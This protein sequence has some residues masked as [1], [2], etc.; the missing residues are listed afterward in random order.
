MRLLTSEPNGIVDG[1]WEKSDDHS[2]LVLLRN[3]EWW[4]DHPTAALNDVLDVDGTNVVNAATAPRSKRALAAFVYDLGSDEVTDVSAPT[5]NF[6][7]FPFITGM[8][9]SLPATTPPNDTISVTQTPRLGTG[10]V[11]INVPNWASNDHRSTL[12]F[13]DYH[14]TRPMVADSPVAPSADAGPLLAYLTW[15][16][17]DDDGGAPITGYRIID[18]SDATVATVA[19]DVFDVAILGLAEGSTP[20]FR[21]IA[22]NSEGESAPSEA[23]A[24][25]TIEGAV[26]DFSDLAEDDPFFAE[27][28]WAVDQGLAAG[29]DDG[30]FGAARPVTRQAAAA[31]LHRLSGSPVG[32]F[33]DPG[34]TDVPV[35]HPFYDEIAWLADEG[36]TEGQPDGSFGPTQPLSRQALAAFL[37]RLAD[38][39]AGPFPDPGFTDV[40]VGHPFYDEIAWLAAAGITDGYDDGTFR[41]LTTV[42]RQ[43]MM[44]FLYRHTL[45]FT[46]IL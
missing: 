1:L 19:A 23:S 36:I 21:V 32:P 41:P 45:V 20:T 26:A 14:V 42:S 37:H 3:K 33:P 18:E 10:P 7:A 43:A 4:G 15:T 39:P 29:Y 13:N 6:A 44:A 22:I 46:I 38:A 9:V 28:N 16:P 27:I 25:V 31:F 30:T 17:P 2:N 34:F 11:T 12:Q 5:P 8:D 40:P 35:G 24:A